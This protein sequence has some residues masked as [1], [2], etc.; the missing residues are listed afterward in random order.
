MTKQ[1]FFL[2]FSF[3]STIALIAQPD[4]WQQR[5]EYKM[6]I[7]MDAPRHQLTGTQQLKYF[8]NSPDTLHRIFYHLYFNAFRPGSMMDMYNRD[9]KRADPRVG[10]RIKN[11]KE[12]EY[13]WHKIKS[14]KCNGKA[15]KYEVNETILEVTLA[16]PI[17]PHSTVTLDMEFSSQVPLQVRRSGRDSKGGIDFS[18]SQWYPKMCEYDYQGWH[19]DPYVQR[20]FYGVWGDF[21]VNITIDRK[22]MLG[23]SGILQNSAEIGKGYEPE[24][25]AVRPAPGDKYTWR[26]K[27]ENVHDFS[28]AADPDYKHIR[29]I[30]KDGV[31]LHFLYQPGDKD[32]SKKWEAAPKQMDRAMDFIN[33]TFGQYPYKAYSFIQAGDG[34]MEYPMAT[35]LAGS[36]G[37]GT[38]VHE[39]MHAWFYG[40]LG[41]NESLYPW[42]DEG[43][44]E[45]AESEVMNFLKKEKVI[46][47]TPVDDPHLS[48]VEQYISFAKSGREE[49]MTTHADHYL[50]ASAYGVAAY[51]KGHVFLTQLQYIMGK[52]IFDRAMLRYFNTWKFKHPNA[53]DFIRIME[54]ESGLELDWF[55]EYFVQTLKTIDYGVVSVKKANRKQTKIILQRA[56]DMPMPIDL[57]VTYK[58][59]KK[60]YFT[61]PLSIMLG[62]KKSDKYGNDITVLKDWRWTHPQYEFLLDDK[63]K[64]VES[65]EIDASKR[66][67][68]T[69]RGNNRWK[70]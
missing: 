69:D 26:W 51:V 38:F 64:K 11:L 60:K 16:E 61:I 42:M 13:G 40:M 43:F 14:L 22:Y 50:T 2:L 39:W 49:V 20:E 46:S 35:F 30:R 5:V 4:G 62:E 3:F 65:L 37:L 41:N 24:G 7:N 66:M 23:A 29:L 58:G 36:A 67:A 8:N 68:D 19:A 1:I 10:D 31:E 52:P 9:P 12:S 32:M 70:K 45:Y 28:W 34:G 18:M 17:L 54:K 44:T 15:A 25:T 53:N 56:G 27:A 47:G 59:G 21:E 33:K 55:K 63:F 6:D 48:A 57:L